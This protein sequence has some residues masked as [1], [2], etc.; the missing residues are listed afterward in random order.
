M[1]YC[2]MGGVRIPFLWVASTGTLNL[3]LQY[4]WLKEM[5]NAPF[6]FIDEFDAF[7]HHELSYAICRRLF[8]G[9][10]QLFLTTHDTYLL[11][12]DLLRPDSFFYLKNNK[13]DALCD[14]TDKEL[15]QGHNLEKLY[16][17]GTFG[18]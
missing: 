2:I 11:T 16:R 12:N 3:E 4:Y 8:G 5:V 15:R 18:V 14:L 13:I 10:N 1:L 7:Y 6:V 17:G 9:T